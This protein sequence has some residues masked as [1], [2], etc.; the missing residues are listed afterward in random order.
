VPAWVTSF[1][2]ATTPLPALSELQSALAS[3]WYTLGEILKLDE[4]EVDAFM[5]QL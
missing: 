1:L 5:T 2:H 4:D 3:D